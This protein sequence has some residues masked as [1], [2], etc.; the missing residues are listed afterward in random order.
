MVDA[1]VAAGGLKH[2]PVTGLVSQMLILVG[3]VPPARGRTTTGPLEPTLTDATLKKPVC[4]VESPTAPSA[5]SVADSA[6]M[7]GVGS[8]LA[9]NNSVLTP[10]VTAAGATLSQRNENS[11]WVAGIGELAVS[12]SR[13]LCAP[14]AA[15]ATGVLG[16]PVT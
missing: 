4:P 8:E 6:T 7:S 1:V 11:T 14:F 16:V 10:T 9:E 5:D 15:T 13:K 2:S 12:A 3:E